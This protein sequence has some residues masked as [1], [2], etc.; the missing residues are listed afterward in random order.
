MDTA[1]EWRCCLEVPEVA[2]KFHQEK[3]NS[4]ADHESFK[5][6]CLNHHVLQLSYFEYIQ[7]NGPLGDE[8]D[9]EPIHE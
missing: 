4:I 2:R 6:N 3:L 5:V 1:R 8:G 7:D 9:E